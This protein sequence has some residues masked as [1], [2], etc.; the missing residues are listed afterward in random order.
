MQRKPLYFRKIGKGERHPPMNDYPANDS[1]ST[2]VD[3]RASL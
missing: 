3:S 2:L 1:Q